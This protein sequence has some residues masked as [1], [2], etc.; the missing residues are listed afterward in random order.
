MVGNLV[1]GQGSEQVDPDLMRRR[2]VEAEVARLAT[3]THD[4]RPH[5]V[6]CCFVLDGEHVYSAVDAKPKSTLALKRLANLRANPYA[7]VLVDHYADDWSTLW[8]IRMDGDARVIGS[9]P[10]RDRALGLLT[11]KY[12]HYEVQPPPGSVVAVDVAAWRAWP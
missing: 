1:A 12:Q 6:P 9:G 2:V 5:V 10:E 7:S 3:V 11:S 8:W 4:G